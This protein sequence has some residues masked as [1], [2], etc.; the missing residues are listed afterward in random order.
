MGENECRVPLCSLLANRPRSRGHKRREETRA[1]LFKGA[2][3]K[4]LFLKAE[5][6]C[7]E[8]GNTL[9]RKG[10]VCVCV[11]HQSQ[12]VI[13]PSN[14]GPNTGSKY[15]HWCITL[16][17]STSLHRYTHTHT[18]PNTYTRS[19]INLSDSCNPRVTYLS[20]RS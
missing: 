8:F 9:K 19:N 6:K 18:L 12:T 2:L 17:I 16:K 14:P 3:I 10:C 5:S 1:S 15:Y 11:C 13:C 4:R 20:F 7:D